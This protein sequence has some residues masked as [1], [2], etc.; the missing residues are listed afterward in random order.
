LPPVALVAPAVVSNWLW[1]IRPDLVRRELSLVAA[2]AFHGFVIALLLCFIL[3]APRVNSEVL[4][5]AISTYLLMGVCWALTYTLD[6]LVPQAFRFTLEPGA[7]RPLEGFESVYFSFSTLTT[8]GYRDIVPV[9]GVAR[10]LTMMESTLGTF[11]V[12]VL[13]ARLVAVYA[14]SA[15]SPSGPQIA[16]P[17]EASKEVDAAETLEAA[18]ES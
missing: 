16:A 4:C 5:A 13:V 15:A 8:V 9:A 11:Y 3:T 18:K 12:A 14:T 17:P 1:H 6:R 2:V 10:M 7:N